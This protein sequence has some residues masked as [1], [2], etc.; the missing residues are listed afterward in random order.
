MPL[1]ER[2][3]VRGLDHEEG[4]RPEFLVRGHSPAEAMGFDP[5]V[6]LPPRP[7][8]SLFGHRVPPRRTSCARWPAALNGCMGSQNS[9][10]S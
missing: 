8:Y 5:M 10:V 9:S 7:F 1:G 4:P 2:Q 3:Q 6:T